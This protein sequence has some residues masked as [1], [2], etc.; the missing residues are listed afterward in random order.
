MI[1]RRWQSVC[2]LFDLVLA[3][4]FFEGD[5]VKVSTAG[6]EQLGCL[7]SYVD[8]RH[9]VSGCGC[10]EAGSSERYGEMLEC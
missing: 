6:Y 1:A 9:L 8:L 3:G 7:D 5:L 10:E 2:L 4:T